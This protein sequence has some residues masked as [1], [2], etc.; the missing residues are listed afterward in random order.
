MIDGISTFKD[1]LIKPEEIRDFIAKKRSGEL[2]Y[3]DADEVGYVNR[4]ENLAEVFER[5]EDFKQQ[6]DIIDFDD[7][8][9]LTH[10]MLTDPFTKPVLEEL[11][12]T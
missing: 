5:L 10:E 4:L 9:L 1:E 2:P 12:N 8:I 6:Q 11:Q 3:K 7:L